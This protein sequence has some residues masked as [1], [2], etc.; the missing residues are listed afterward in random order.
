MSESNTATDLTWSEQ[1]T[2]G[3]QRMDET[4]EEFVDMLNE[5]LATPEDQQMPLYMRFLDHTVDHFSQE[6]RWMVAVGFEAENCH[7]SH[8]A[9]ILETMRA[10]IEHYEQGDTEIITRLAQALAEWFPQHAATMDAG[11]AQH[12]REVGF[13]SRTETLADPSRIKPAT[14]SGCGSVSCS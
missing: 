14:M 7:A 3:D 6:E 8:H 13:N 11:L 12:M 1:L 9:T 10:V 4:H 2:T 5:I